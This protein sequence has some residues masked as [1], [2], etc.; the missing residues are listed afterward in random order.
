MS[1]HYLRFEEDLEQENVLFWLQESG[2]MHQTEQEDVFDWLTGADAGYEARGPLRTMTRHQTSLTNPSPGAMG[3]TSEISPDLIQQIVKPLLEMLPTLIPLLV[4]LITDL[5]KALVESFTQQRKTRDEWEAS[6]EDYQSALEDEEWSAE[7]IQFLPLLLQLLPLLVPLIMPLVTALIKTLAKNSGNQPKTKEEWEALI[8]ASRSALEDEEWSA[9][10]IQ[11]LPLLLQLLPLL[12][13]LI[14]P[15]VTALI[16]TL[17]KNFG[18]QPKTKEEWEALIEANQSALAEDLFG[19]IRERLEKVIQSVSE[20]SDIILP[21]MT[22]FVV[23][24]MKQ[25]L[26][27][28]ARTIK[29]LPKIPE[30]WEAVAAADRDEAESEDWSDGLESGDGVLDEVFLEEEEGEEYGS[31]NDTIAD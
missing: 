15:L 9:E 10:A 25:A 28:L 8:E 13:P 19:Q 16:K 24:L 4:P 11:F 12:V 1:D 6:V 3:V 2:P 23:P 20:F 14:M 30:D 17:A 27:L 7:A 22:Q 18:N 29:D 21:L 26:P 31:K 5:I